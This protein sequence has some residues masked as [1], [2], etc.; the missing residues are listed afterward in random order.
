MN[1]VLF[2]LT[3]GFAYGSG[4]ISFG[5]LTESQLHAGWTVG[6]GFE[7]AITKNISA[8]AEYMHFELDRKNYLRGTPTNLAIASAE[9]VGDIVKV[10]VNYRFTF[11]PPVVAPPPRAVIAKY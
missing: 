11:E 3:G 8:K 7:F 6:G 9:H 5:G 2:Y 4:R 10:G 1:N